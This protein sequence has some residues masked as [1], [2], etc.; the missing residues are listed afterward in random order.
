MFFRLK[1]LITQKVEIDVCLGYFPFSLFLFY[2]APQKYTPMHRRW[3]HGE[4]H[5]RFADSPSTLWWAKGLLLVLKHSTQMKGWGSAFRC[6]NVVQSTASL[7]PLADIKGSAEGCHLHDNTGRKP[8]P[9]RALVIDNTSTL[10]QVPVYVHVFAFLD[11]W[12][13]GLTLCVRVCESASERENY[14]FS[15]VSMTQKPTFNTD[16]WGLEPPD[17]MITH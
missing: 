12:M 14:G 17:I 1:I 10:P 16:F 7:V 6:G 9:S 2:G 3:S 8:V 4:Y 13:S 5:W 15:V 11:E